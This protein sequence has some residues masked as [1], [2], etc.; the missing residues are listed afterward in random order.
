ML[1]TFFELKTKF[2]V[3][4]IFK[5]DINFLKSQNGLVLLIKKLEKNDY[6]IFFLN[7]II[8]HPIQWKI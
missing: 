3:K 2:H 7:Q 4:I 1:T 5:N 8:L 6:K